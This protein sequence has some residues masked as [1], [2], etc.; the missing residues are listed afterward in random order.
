MKNLILLLLLPLVSTFA[1]ADNCTQSDVAIETIQV[2]DNIYMLIGQGGN[3]GL[4]VDEDYTLMIDDQFAPLSEAIK[5]EIAKLTEK[6]ITYLLNTHFHFDHTDGNANFKDSVGVIVAHE[7]VRSKLKKGAVIEAFGKTMEPYAESAL[8]ALTYSNKL[9]IHQSNEAIE[10]LHFANAHT[11]GDT[12]VHFKDSNVIHSGDIYFSGMYPFIDTSNGGSVHGVIAA[13]EALLALADDQTKII[14][15]HGL[16]SDKAGLERDLKML[17][18]I[19]AVVK[20]EL[21]AGKTYDQIAMHA[22]IE[23]YDVSYGQGILDVKTF[24]GMLGSDVVP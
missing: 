21:A 13:Q 18:E 22:T 15:G 6:P 1:M 8:P 11:D 2:A 3:I 23:K 14:P 4:A 10:L 9:S 5:E 7:N 24:I 20:S 17:K 12:A 16:L 19:V